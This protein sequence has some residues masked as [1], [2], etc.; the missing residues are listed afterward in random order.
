MLKNT[1]KNYLPWEIDS[2]LFPNNQ[3]INDRLLFLLNYALLSP[4]AHNI[5]PWSFRVKEEKIFIYIEKNRTLKDSDPI[6]R[7]LYESMGACLETIMIAGDHFG[8]FLSIN[9]DLD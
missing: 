2:A 4:S 3:G 7:Q 5:Q 9:Y 1:K 8:I 6:S